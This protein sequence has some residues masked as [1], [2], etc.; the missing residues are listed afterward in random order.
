VHKHFTIVLLSIA[1]LLLSAVGPMRPARAAPAVIKTAVVTP[2]GSTWVKVLRQ[3]AAEVKDQTQGAVDISIYAGGVSG[4]EADVLRKMQVNRIHAAGLSGVGLGIILPEVRVLEAP[5]LFKNDSE[6]DAVRAQIF[7]YF[8]AAFLKKGYVL[9][10]FT[11]GGWVYLFSQQDLGREEAF[12]SAKMWVWEGDKVAETLLRNFGVRT[13]P[14]HIAEVNTGLETHMIDSFYA[15]PL[16]A[17]AFQ[18]H[19]RVQYLLDFPLVDSTAGLLMS[20]RAFEA[21][22]T[23]QQAIL[24]QSAGKHCRQLVDL[25]R[26]E[27][28]DAL[29][30]LQ[31]QGLTFVQPTQEQLITFQSD[32]RKT[33]A[34]SIPDLYPQALFD[35]IQAILGRLRDTARKK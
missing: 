20:R 6:I 2:E 17:I 21:L 33:Y 14:L 10:G 24:K 25:T 26:K 35:Q 27:N 18:W 32:A 5:L 30:V 34:Q 9:L 8:A 7:D 12:K 29:D 23:E 22:S 16:A 28:R 19:T 11:E 1:S 4:D 3:M 13:T 31:S 15:P